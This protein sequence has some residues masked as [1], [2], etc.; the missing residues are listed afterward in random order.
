[1][2]VLNYYHGVSCTVF[3]NNGFSQ[4]MIRYNNPVRFST[5]PCFVSNT[6]V[7]TEISH[8]QLLDGLPW[9]FMKT[10]IVSSGWIVMTIFVLS[11]GMSFQLASEISQHLRDG[12]ASFHTVMIAR[13]YNPDSKMLGHCIQQSRM[14]M[15]YNLWPIKFSTKIRYLM[16][17]LINII[18][19]CE[20]TL[21]N[22]AKEVMFSFWCVG[23]F[24]C[25]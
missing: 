23:L 16:F 7:Q 3:C 9:N 11:A 1:M 25:Q 24:V 4:D 19:F 12:F 10:F 5:E 8:P 20:Y 14:Q 22:S 21:I 2:S 18:V 17:K 6:L 13:W 15:L